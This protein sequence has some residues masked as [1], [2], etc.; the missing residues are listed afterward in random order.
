MKAIPL[1]QGYVTWV[2]DDVYEWA[3]KYKWHVECNHD[4]KNYAVRHIANKP[5]TSSRLHREILGLIKGDGK[6]AD[7]IN[8]NT[9]LNTGSNLRAT[10]RYGNA[11]NR[12][13]HKNKSS[14]YKGVCISKYINKVRWR[15]QIKTHKRRIHLGTFKTEIEAAKAYN[16]AALKHHGEFARLNNV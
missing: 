6:F 10:D 4:G 15:S 8:G 16:V 9:L 5:R 14:K 3:S 13:K 2:D 1:T 12:G 7:H 11:K